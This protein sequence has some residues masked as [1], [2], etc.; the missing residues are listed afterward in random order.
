[1]L[2]TR[3]RPDIR[4]FLTSAPI[5]TSSAVPIARVSSETFSNTRPDTVT[6]GSAPTARW[7]TGGVSNSSIWFQME[8]AIFTSAAV[9]ADKARL[10]PAS[11][12]GKMDRVQQ[13]RHR[14][15]RAVLEAEITKLV[16]YV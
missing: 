13:C 6:S 5:R 16:K 8:A 14:L 15:E 4:I 12:V 11:G 7:Q 2:R 1:M 9:G 3:R 10:L